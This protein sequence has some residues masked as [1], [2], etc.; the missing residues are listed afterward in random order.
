VSSGARRPSRVPPSFPTPAPPHN[1]ADLDPLLETWEADRKFHRCYDISWGSRDFYAGDDAHRGRFHPFTPDGGTEP[2][3]VLYGASDFDGAVY[4]TVFHDVP[5]RGSKHLAHAQLVHRLVVARVARRDLILADLTSD[6]LRR[7]GLT[8]GNSSSPTHAAIRRRRRGPGPSTTTPRGSTGCCGSPVSAT[9]A[10]RS[11]CLVTG[12]RSAN[13]P[14]PPGRFRSPSAPAR[15]WR[16]SAP[17]PTAPASPSP[18][19][20]DTRSGPSAGRSPPPP[21]RGTRALCPPA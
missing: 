10:A 6:G 18:A 16:R 20:P 8:R 4:E 13:S 11:S 2:L 3:P 19:A 17:P 9:L 5:I 1:P 7:L 15:G 12:S 14:P 21:C